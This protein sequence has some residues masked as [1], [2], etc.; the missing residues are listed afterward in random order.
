MQATLPTPSPEVQAHSDR[1]LDHVIT[2][3]EQAGGWLSFA[4]YMQLVL[5][6]PGLGYYLAG[7]KKLGAAGDFVTAPQLS[8]LFGATLANQLAQ[9]L[10]YT[11]GN[12]LELGAGSGRLAVQVLQQLDELGIAP[13]QYFILEPSAELR[14][15]QKKILSND[16]FSSKIIW[17]TDLPNSFSGVM[18]GNEV[19]DALPVEVVKRSQQNWL[20]CGVAWQDKLVWAERAL[21]NEKLAEAAHARWPQSCDIYV[22]EINLTAEA[23]LM[24]LAD[25]LAQGAL[26]FIDYGFPAR[27]YYHPQRDRGTLLCHYRHHVHDDIFF[28]PGLQDITAHIDFTAMA[29][30]AHSAGLEVSGYTTQAQFLLNCGVLDLLA[31]YK[32]TSLAYI[33]ECAAVQKLLSPAEMGE[34]VKAIAF[35]KNLSVPWRGFSQGDLRLRL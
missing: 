11:E 35:S 29:Q 22:S 21:A 17:L 9:I 23:L 3:I 15:R 34:L 14:E 4:D 2:H 6:A 19:L 27:E 31:R 12:I 26:L 1:V 25:R 5:Y 20:Q 28:L 7:A 30:A 18:I 24:T 33:R 32:P 8:A 13:A 16:L 10:P